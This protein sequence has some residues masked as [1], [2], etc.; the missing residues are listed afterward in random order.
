ML[1]IAT[2]GHRFSLFI[3]KNRVWWEISVDLFF[4]R[5]GGSGWARGNLVALVDGHAPALIGLTGSVEVRRSTA[6]CMH[7]R[8]F[9]M[10]CCLA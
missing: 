2:D 9:R 5:P 4:C 8:R 3:D 10:R 1:V 7:G 6:V